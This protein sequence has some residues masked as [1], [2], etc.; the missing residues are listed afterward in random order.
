[1]QSGDPEQPDLWTSVLLSVVCADLADGED[2]PDCAPE[3]A[4]SLL[5]NTAGEERSRLLSAGDSR[6][7]NS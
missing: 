6:V 2:S 1:M 4:L 5:K 7:S 3:S